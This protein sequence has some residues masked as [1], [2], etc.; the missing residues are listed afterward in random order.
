MAA[1]MKRKQ[2]DYHHTMEVFMNIILVGMPASGK[3]TA[4]VVLAKLLGLDYRERVP[5]Y[6]RW[7]DFTL[8]GESIAHTAEQIKAVITNHAEGC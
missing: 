6:K 1:E 4:G 7:A 3:S 8:E 5:L 2:C